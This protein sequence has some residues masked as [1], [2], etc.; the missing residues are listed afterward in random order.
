MGSAA[1]LLTEKPNAVLDT[2][3]GLAIYSWHDIFDAA[4]PVFTKDPKATLEHPEIQFRAQRARA[5]F[6]LALFL[7]EN[8]WKT[9]VP[10]NEVL[11]LLLKKAPPTGAEQGIKSNFVRLFLYFIKDELLTR[12][13]AGGD[14][15]SDAHLKGDD[16]DRLCL[17][18]ADQHRIPLIS[19]EGHGPNG[20]DASKLIPREAKIRGTDLV[21]PEALVRRH[22]FDHVPAVRRFLSDWD[23]KAPKYLA[24]KKG[25]DR[26]NAEELLAHARP[27]F[28][29]LADD[30]WTP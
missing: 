11:R 30:D 5:A 6:L 7:D 12:W 13:E 27:F 22:N 26:R 3:V 14:V 19:W 15:A 25:A 28:Q 23:R 29:R 20:L 2:N 21:T 1:D 4:D 9:L 18:W 10:L 24:D 8:G 16:V 17:G